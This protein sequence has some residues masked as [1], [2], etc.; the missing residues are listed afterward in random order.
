MR[1]EHPAEHGIM[2]GW[3]YEQK[4]SYYAMSNWNALLATATFDASVKASVSPS[5]DGGAPLYA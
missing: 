1:S 2:N 5:S 4:M 3:T